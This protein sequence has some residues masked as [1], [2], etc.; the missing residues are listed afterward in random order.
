VAL[1]ERESCSVIG[2]GF[3]GEAGD[4]VGADGGVGE[5]IV[6]QVDAAGV[7]FGAVPAV[8]RGENPIGA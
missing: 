2:F 8:H 5:A 6:D 4:Y 1:D 3:A 7:V